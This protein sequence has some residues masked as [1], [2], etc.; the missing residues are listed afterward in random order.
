MDI[1]NKHYPREYLSLKIDYI[2]KA[3]KR[4]PDVV[5]HE[6]NI[7]GVP[8]TRVY[9]DNH[10]YNADS[11]LGKK[12]LDLMRRRQ[13]L[14][15]ELELY[16]TI[17]NYSYN[18]ALPAEITAHCAQRRMWI[19]TDKYVILDKKYFDSLEPDANTEYEKPKDYE[20]NGTYYRSAAEREMAIFYTDMGIEFKY[21]PKVYIKGLPNSIFPDFIL[22]I[23]ELNNC[24]FQEHFGVKNSS[25]Y[26]KTTSFK[27]SNYANAGLEPEVDIIYTH[28]TDDLPFDIRELTHKLN[29]AIYSTTIR[30]LGK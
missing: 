14:E 24:K 5:L 20:F 10:R 6:H 30:T 23:R 1:L 19:D 16:E 29:T 8:T 2:K 4:M 17:W 28:D 9:V 18:D 13:Q 11:D 21:E 3:L 26:L 7:A 25:T 22:L 27:Y 15:R 12:Y